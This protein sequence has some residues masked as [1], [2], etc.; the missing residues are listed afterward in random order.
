MVHFL[1]HGQPLVHHPITLLTMPS[2]ASPA[3]P[4]DLQAPEPP[5]SAKASHVNMM[6]DTVIANMPPEGLRVV[7]RG[8]LGVDAKVTPALNSLAAEYLNTTSFTTNP[9]LFYS[10]KC[11]VEACALVD[12]QQRY[13]CLMGC[14]MGFRSMELLNEVLRQ[15]LAVVLLDG[16]D[17]SDHLMDILAIVDADMVQA[18][19]AVQKELLTTSGMREMTIEE[20]KIV[21][22][23]MDG[24][25]GCQKQ[26]ETMGIE[27]PFKRGL[28][29]IQKVGGMPGVDMPQLK[30]RAVEPMVNISAPTSPPP[31]SIE[32]VQLGQ[33]TVPR[34]FMG[35]NHL[36]LHLTSVFLRMCP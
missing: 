5:A 24:L 34:M 36:Y 23:L 9:Q 17:I 3:L 13:R 30:Q 4:A 8:L 22:N 32:R 35:K 14:G 28:S 11:P 31:N 27:F 15:V 7:L 29:R 25:L 18:V 21:R 12:F 1:N 2:V 20:A 6:T 26:S 10:R 16:Q 19:T 33:S